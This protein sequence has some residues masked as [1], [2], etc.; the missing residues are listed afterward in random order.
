MKSRRIIYEN[1]HE[2]NISIVDINQEINAV[3][4]RTN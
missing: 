3:N 2:I 1:L 4:I